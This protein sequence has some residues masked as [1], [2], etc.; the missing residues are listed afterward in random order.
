MHSGWGKYG[1]KG[2]AEEGKKKFGQPRRRRRHTL[3]HTQTTATHGPSHPTTCVGMFDRSVRVYAQISFVLA[4]RLACLCPRTCSFSARALSPTIDFNRFWSP[5]MMVGSSECYQVEADPFTWFDCAE[6]P[7]SSGK[8][9][10]GG[11]GE[12]RG[13]RVWIE[14]DLSGGGRS[15]AFRSVKAG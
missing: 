13:M 12:R 5:R 3:A 2:M 1:G 14:S 4:R 11:G 8:S 7:S 9:A 6:R 15:V 10:K